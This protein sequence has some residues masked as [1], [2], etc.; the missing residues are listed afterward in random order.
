[1]FEAET[2]ML[3]P[4]LE[5]RRQLWPDLRE[6]AVV[7]Q[8]HGVGYGV[9]DLAIFDLDDSKIH[10]RVEAGLTTPLLS[11]SVLATYLAI[12]D[13]GPVSLED[14]FCRVAQSR[15]NLKYRLI[16][17]LLGT[18]YLQQ[19]GDQLYVKVPGYALAI[20]TAIA[21]EAKL[22]DWR[23]GLHQAQ[24]Y[25]WFAQRV[26][27]AMD[28]DYVHRAAANLDRFNRTNVGL[29]NVSDAHVDVLFEPIPQG[30][31]SEL[32]L[33]LSNEISFKQAIAS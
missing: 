13:D 15:K 12:A 5:S 25:Q 20:D 6:D 17:F 8:E 33:H 23:R 1:M 27:L 10:T 29:I 21:I 14:I 3:V 4:L 26:Y 32:M 9:A 31:F 24:R 18:G 22:S 11:R 7:I 16:P 19:V 30:P 2:Q 28:S